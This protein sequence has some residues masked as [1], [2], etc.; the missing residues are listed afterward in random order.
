MMMRVLVSLILGWSLSLPASADSVQVAVASNFNGAMEQIAA[1]F[2]KDT[3]HTVTLMPAG[4]GK[5]YA[6][7]KN[8]APFDILLSA[9]DQ[10][11]RKLEEEGLAV[12][13]SRFTYALGKLVLWSAKP[14]TVDR[15]GKVLRKGEFA[16]ISLGN[17]KTVPYGKAAVE[18]LEHLGLL[19]TLEAKFVLGEN[20]AHAQQFVASGNAELGFVAKSGVYRDGRLTGGSAWWIPD[21]LYSP[22][23]QDAVLLRKAQDNAAAKALL[24]YLQSGTAQG[25]MTALGYGLNK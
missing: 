25:I 3:G 12:P 18:V 7:I 1:A 11:P 21:D 6:Q 23:R 10:T 13:G 5:L 15:E 19:Q 14:T 22:I 16:H 20:V 2:R 4:T 24:D 17:P 8:G 9:D